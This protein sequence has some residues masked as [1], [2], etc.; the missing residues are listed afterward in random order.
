VDDAVE[1]GLA[2]L[3]KQQNADGSC[4]GGGPRVRDDRSDVDVD[5]RVRPHAGRRSIRLTVR[6]AIDFELRQM[7]DDG[8]IGKVDG[9]R[10][11]GQGIATLALAE[12]LGVET[13]ETGRQN[14]RAALDRAVKVILTAQDVPKDANGAAGGATSDVG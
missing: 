4:D 12:A 2:F 8:Y 3:A 5:A 11:Y 13:T 9:S 7:P 1:R 10:M 6:R 14:I